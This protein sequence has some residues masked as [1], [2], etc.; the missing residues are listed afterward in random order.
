MSFPDSSDDQVITDAHAAAGGT[1]TGATG[2]RPGRRG[3]AA[4]AEEAAQLAEALSASARQAAL[5]E[6]RRARE[7]A[8]LLRRI[9]ELSL[10]DK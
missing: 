5:D 6:E 1:G 8:E 7:D 2:P 3:P 10:S 4:D 9:L